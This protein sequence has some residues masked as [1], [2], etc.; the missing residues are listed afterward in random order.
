MNNM[1]IG[2]ADN[3]DNKGWYTISDGLTGMVVDYNYVSKSDDSWSAYGDFS[4]SHGI[5]GGNPYFS[6]VNDPL[7]PDGIPFTN[8]D[9]LRPSSQSPACSSG[10]DGIDIGAYSCNE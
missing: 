6:N 8:D 4:E 10:E 3:R 2:C 1:F 7:G 5:N 9:G